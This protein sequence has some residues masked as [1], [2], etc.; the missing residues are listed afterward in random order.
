MT[1]T[2][3]ASYFGDCATNHDQ[4][5]FQF[6]NSL[7]FD[8]FVSF[9]RSG[10]VTPRNVFIFCVWFC[11]QDYNFHIQYK[12][13]SIDLFTKSMNT[14]IKVQ[15]RQFF[16]NLATSWVAIKYIFIN[17]L[18]CAHS[19]SFLICLSTKSRNIEI[20]NSYQF[21]YSW[22]S[23]NSR[24]HRWKIHSP[25][26]VIRLMR[27]PLAGFVFCS[28]WVMLMSGYTITRVE[29]NIDK[30]RWNVLTTNI[31]FTILQFICVKF[32]EWLS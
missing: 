24:I 27:W 29:K 19:K 3:Q 8:F 9:Y 23:T 14:L 25:T 28:L 17:C 10:R 5:V 6:T 16:R 11:V 13:R 18:L 4:F 26:W 12:M 32:T 2:P 22:L 1:L 21:Q 30:R 15:K 7:H 20:G 31:F